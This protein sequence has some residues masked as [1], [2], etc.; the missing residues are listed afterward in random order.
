[1]EVVMVRYMDDFNDF[2]EDRFIDNAF[3]VLLFLIFAFIGYLLA[4]YV[5]L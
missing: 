4:N 5:G 3:A 2:P 1:V